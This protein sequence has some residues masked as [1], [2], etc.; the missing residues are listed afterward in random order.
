VD[1]ENFDKLKSAYDACLDEDTIKELGLG[2][3]LEILNE[4]SE[5]HPTSGAAVAED[6]AALSDTILYL[7]K[8]GVSALV[9]AGTGPDDTDPD[10]VVVSVSP[11]YRLGLLAKERYKEEKV[12]KQYEETLSQVIS[13]LYPDRKVDGHAIVELEK[14]LAAAS[15]DAE[16]RDDVTV[17]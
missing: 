4:I 5:L 1:E 7:A 10:T 13:A 16:D 14:K 17:F 2:P 8:L 12:V 11:P 9:S 3:L 15:P 6:D